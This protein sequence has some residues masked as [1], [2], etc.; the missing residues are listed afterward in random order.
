MSE[1][2]DGDRGAAAESLLVVWDDSLGMRWPG[3]HPMDGRR[4]VLCVGLLEAIGA[5]S[6]L[7][8][9]REPGPGPLSDDVLAQIFA[10]A[11]VRAIERYSA[12]PKLGAGMEAS[13]FGI[14]ADNGAYAGMHEDAAALAGAAARVAEQVA[15]GAQTRTF[16]PGGGSHHGTASR[17]SGFGVYNETAVSV[18]AALDAGAER[19]AYID[20]DVHH[21]DGTQWMYYEN[22]DVLTVSVHESGRHLF[23]G[24]GFAAETGGPGAEGT[25]ANVPLPPFSGDDEWLAAIDQIVLPVVRAFS[26]DLLITQCGVDHHHADPLSHHRTTM[27]LYPQVW[28]RLDTLSTEVCD[29]RWVAHGGGGYAYCGAA[30]RAWALLAAQMAGVSVDDP[31][32]EEW[33]ERAVEM[34]CEDPPTRW[35]EDDPPPRSESERAMAETGT[36]DALIRSRIALQT[37][38]AL[39]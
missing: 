35:L 22:P 34:G 8:V 16:L 7:A 19:V 20:L 38:G 36:A 15:S 13:Q 23:P 5:F 10:P 29:G 28:E 1:H 33:R 21:G 2:G 17:A 31:L 25:A 26:P 32:P 11:F 39:P 6:G 14:G 9:R 12:N 24:S 3:E 18:A 27:A 30:P 4:H 37:A